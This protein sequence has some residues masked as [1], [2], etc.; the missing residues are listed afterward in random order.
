MLDEGQEKLRR[1]EKQREAE[2]AGV[3]TPEEF[4]EYELRNSATATALRSQMSGFEPTEEEFRRIFRLQ[5]T[6][7]NDFNQAFDASDPNQSAVKARAQQQAQDAL[8]AEIKKSLGEER[9][10]QWARGQD[11]DYKALV[12][13]AERFDLPKETANRIYDMKQDAERQ[14]Q[15]VD[16]NP[17]LTDDQRGKALAAIARETQKA[18]SATMGDQIFKAYQRA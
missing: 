15:K 16:G 17:N 1:I 9:Y 18:V 5:K 13:V 14:K 11:S 10:N 8:N 3:L 12:Q 7:D 2:L 6:F 4:E